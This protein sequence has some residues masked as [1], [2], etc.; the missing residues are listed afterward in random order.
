MQCNNLI[1]ILEI[2]L[3]A[4]LA[5]AVIWIGWLQLRL[6]EKTRQDD[7][8][9]RRFDFIKR[10]DHSIEKIRVVV[11]SRLIDEDD[12]FFPYVCSGLLDGEDKSRLFFEG[13]FE[14]SALFSEFKLLFGR[15]EY[16]RNFK[17]FEGRNK[18]YIEKDKGLSD[19][20][21]MIIFAEKFLYDLGYEKIKEKMIMLTSLKPG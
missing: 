7:L 6:K 19:D 4:V 2:V 8:F 11:V 20:D 3:K 9:D 21:A 18:K 14:T 13:F 17:S 5:G 10:F 15:D 16:V 1:P 12:I